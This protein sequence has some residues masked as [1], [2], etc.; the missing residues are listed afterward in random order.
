MRKVRLAVWLRPCVAMS[1]VLSW[2][3]GNEDDPLA[4][5]V[6][7]G[8][9]TEARVECI[10]WWPRAFTTEGR[11]HSFF[12]ADGLTV[13][14]VEE[15][16]RGGANPNAVDDGH[17]AQESVLGPVT[18][19]MAAAAYADDPAVIDVL[20]AAGARLVPLVL[21]AAGGNGSLSVVE[22]LIGVGADVRARDRHS[23]TPLFRFAARNPN[24]SSVRTLVKAGA[25]PNARNH[26]GE[27]PLS[28]AASHNENPA[29]AIALIEAGADPN[30][31]DNRGM[32]PLHRAAWLATNP[33]VVGVLLD[34][35]A[36]PAAKDASG[37]T[38]M[39]WVLGNRG[40]P[41]RTAIIVAALAEAGADPN[42]LDDEGQTALH[43]AAR[44]KADPKVIGALV[45]E[46][47][48]ADLP[49]NAGKTPIDWAVD[50][51]NPAVVAALRR[52]SS[53]HGGGSSVGLEQQQP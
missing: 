26:N 18:V 21:H 17:H 19:L 16:L 33:G 5:S 49:D 8:L 50:S 42:A 12:G 30:S 6:R 52:T 4:F 27:T 48:Y 3:A 10:D 51:G 31:S 15:C 23:G 53:A 32:S 47:A 14:L 22:R 39:H 40:S 25:D 44:W 45:A 29:V 37:M 46:G 2:S 43:L 34:A 11:L 20:L 38:A 9:P 28:Y 13:E 24:P 35:G 36:N 7:L 41:K 1:A